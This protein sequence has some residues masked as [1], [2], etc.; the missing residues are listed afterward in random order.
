MCVCV[1]VCVCVHIHRQVAM[2][3]LLVAPSIA[4]DEKNWN[5]TQYRRSGNERSTNTECFS[6]GFFTAVTVGFK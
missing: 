5:A 4:W 3:T 6:E 2:Y 1:C